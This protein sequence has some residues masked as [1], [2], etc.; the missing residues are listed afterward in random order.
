MSIWRAAI[1]QILDALQKRELVWHKTERF[2]V[3]SATPVQDLMA[4]L[5]SAQIGGAVGLR[6]EVP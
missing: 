1:A 5:E 6:G 3:L 4:P 2:R